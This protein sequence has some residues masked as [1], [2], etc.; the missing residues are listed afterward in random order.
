MDHRPPAATVADLLSRLV[1]NPGRPR[2]TW[3]GDAGERV[4]LSGAVLE[5]WTTKT[6]NLL[7]EELD[8]GP[9]STVLVDLP[10]HWRT[11]VWTLA[12]WR[13]GACVAFDATD[14]VGAADAVVTDRPDGAAAA[15]ADELV[16]VTLAALARRAEA[17]L[18]PGAI[19]AA[20]AVMTYGD[21]LGWVPPLDPG[22]PAVRHGGSAVT[23][24]DLPSWW[25]PAEPGVRAALDAGTAPDLLRVAGGLF[26]ADGSLVLLSPGR[27]AELVASEGARERVLATERVGTDLSA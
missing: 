6:A 23:H 7:V 15:G 11:L 8:A 26:A 18:P 12:A 22:A 16:V 20:A 25:A 21:R 5:N 19:D 3:Y 10:A 14:L 27:S 1:R 2:I 13:V 9:G 4:E 17:P 24:A